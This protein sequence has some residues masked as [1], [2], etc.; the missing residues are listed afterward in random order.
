[1]KT[2][3]LESMVKDYERRTG[4]RVSFDG[5][6]FN[7]QNNFKDKYNE[8]F[9]FFPGAGF[10]F[11]G[12]LEYNG[13]KVFNILQTYG[14]MK[15]IGRY[16]VDVMKQNDLTQII[17]ATARN[18]KGFIKKWTMIPIPELDYRYYGREYKVLTTTIDHLIETL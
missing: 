4:E 2:K 5:F 3:T 9:Q 6:Y 13:K 10:L 18:T 12:I 17:V 1:M 8:H 11:W 16:I 14:D 15:V 7:E